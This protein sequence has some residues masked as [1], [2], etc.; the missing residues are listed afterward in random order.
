MSVND[1]V[2]VETIRGIE[3]GTVVLPEKELDESS[4]EH[5]LKPVIRLATKQDL[6]TYEKNYERAK[7]ALAQCKE[8]VDRH[9][10]EMKLLDCEYTLDRQK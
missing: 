3:L 4:I 6:N 1:K 7:K 9:G 2:V 10:L 5:E 8:I